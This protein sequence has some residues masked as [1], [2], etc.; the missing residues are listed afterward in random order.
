MSYMFI[1]KFMISALLKYA[2]LT[3]PFSPLSL[4][5]KMSEPDPSF[6]DHIVNLTKTDLHLASIEIQ[7]DMTFDGIDSTGISSQNKTPLAVDEDAETGR[8]KKMHDN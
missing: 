8:K 2:G 7:S 4:F 3:F 6:L 5:S 1:L